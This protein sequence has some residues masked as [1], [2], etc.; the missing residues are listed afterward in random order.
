[1]IVAVVIIAEVVMWFRGSG[2]NNLVQTIVTNTVPKTGIANTLTG[3]TNAITGVTNTLTGITNTITGITNTTT[4]STNSYS[5]VGGHG[6]SFMNISEA[7][8][9]IG[10][11]GQYN[12][13]NTT[14]PD[15]ISTYI[16]EYAPGYTHAYNIT[17]IY[18]SSYILNSS[19]PSSPSLVDIA[20]QTTNATGLYRQM[21]NYTNSSITV[22]NGSV[23]GMTY[24][25]LVGSGGQLNFSSLLG[26]KDNEV[27]TLTLTGTKVNVTKLAATTASDM[28]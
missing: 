27:T 26:W 24:S 13:T 15:L 23:N 8:S 4:I 12:A 19:N 3:I 28:P 21:L 25:Y 16:E 6:Q 22:L 10:P 5:S 9:F 17:A 11:G 1:M 7:A 2:I 14:D 20:F 18:A